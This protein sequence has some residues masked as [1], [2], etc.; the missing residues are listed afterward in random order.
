MVCHFS[1]RRVAV[2]TMGVDAGFVLSS[3]FRGDA[4]V[5]ER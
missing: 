2:E 5:M 1:I 4:E 3:Y